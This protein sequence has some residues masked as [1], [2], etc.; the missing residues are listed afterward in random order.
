[1][2]QRFFSTTA[3]SFYRVL[4]LAVNKIPE[5][6]REAFTKFTKPGG[7][8]KRKLGKIQEVFIKSRNGNPVHQSHYNP[9]DKALVISV[10]IVGSRETKTCHI[11]SDGTGTIKKGDAPQ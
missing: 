10:R 4:G 5:S 6:H 2:S 11:Y 3:Q 1:M 7:V 9:A 8:A